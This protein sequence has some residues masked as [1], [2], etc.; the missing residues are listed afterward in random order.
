[1]QMAGHWG[2]TA[3]SKRK[4]VAALRTRAAEHGSNP[5]PVLSGTSQKQLDTS[6][7]TTVGRAN[8][9]AASREQVLRLAP[10][11]SASTR[12]PMQQPP[13]NLDSQ[14]RRQ[15]EEQVLAAPRLAHPSTTTALSE[16]LR[17]RGIGATLTSVGIAAFRSTTMG[18]T[19]G[20]I[21]QRS[22]IGSRPIAFAK[23]PRLVANIDNSRS[24]SPTTSPSPWQ[25]APR[26]LRRAPLGAPRQHTHE[27]FA[28]QHPIWGNATEQA[29]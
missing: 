16:K 4:H 27:H 14:L 19:S 2:S 9:V 20:C 13:Q 3:R 8:R 10:R 15:K 7:D 5:V 21:A 29:T 6:C 25:S 28:I 23:R 26:A 18:Q 11:H 12:T 1:M 24:T 17:V 22:P